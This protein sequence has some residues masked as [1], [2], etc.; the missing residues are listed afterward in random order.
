MVELAERTALVPWTGE[1]LDLASMSTVG[2]IDMLD[3]IHDFEYDRLRALKRQVQDE[4][5]ARMDH[6]VA[7]GENNHWTVTLGDGRKV[8]G[9][10]PVQERYAIEPLINTLERLIEEGLLTETAAGNALR[11]KREPNVSGIKS[12]RKLGGI[13]NQRLAACLEPDPR[14]RTVTISRNAR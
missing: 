5:L 11:V 14:P 7:S 6:A 12:L 13:I 2:I 3:E 9:T 1:L 8:S 4:L 10:P